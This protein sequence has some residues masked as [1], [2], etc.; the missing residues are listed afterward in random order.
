MEKYLR[1]IQAFVREN[2]SL[3]NRILLFKMSSPG[4]SILKFGGRFRTESCFGVA[5]IEMKE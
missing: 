5:M 4:I 1:P 3:P 2:L